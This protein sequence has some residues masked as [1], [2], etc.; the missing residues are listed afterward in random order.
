MKYLLVLPCP[1]PCIHL[2]GMNLGNLKMMGM[3]KWGLNFRDLGFQPSVSFL[4]LGKE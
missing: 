2:P 1:F 4:P 3:V